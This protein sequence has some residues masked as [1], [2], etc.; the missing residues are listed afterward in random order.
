MS[1]LLERQISSDFQKKVTEMCVRDR[2][3]F[4]KG[5]DRTKEK[6]RKGSYN[7]STHYVVRDE[8]KMQRC[9]AA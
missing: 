2:Q 5:N 3:G 4:A 7:T 6:N 8:L 1:L 9:V